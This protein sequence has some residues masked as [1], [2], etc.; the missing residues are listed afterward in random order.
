MYSILCP[1]IEE[2]RWGSP[3]CLHNGIAVFYRKECDTLLLSDSH[4]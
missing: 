1:Y 4:V 3:T 2:L